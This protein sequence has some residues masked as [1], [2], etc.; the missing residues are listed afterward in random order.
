MLPRH[1]INIFLK[2][3]EHIERIDKT[4]GISE[5][6]YKICKDLLER[7]WKKSQSM[8]LKRT[9]IDWEPYNQKVSSLYWVC[10]T[11]LIAVAEHLLNSLVDKGVDNIKIILPNDEEGCPSYNQLVEF[12]NNPNPLIGNQIELAK[13][14]YEEI[15][16]TLE[17]REKELTEHLRKYSGTMYS[18]ITIYDEDA[19]I[20]FYDKAGIGDENITL[21]F[22]GKQTE[23]YKLVKDLFK[24]MWRDSK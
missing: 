3:K 24:K 13:K 11:S 18:N 15:C 16:K 7:W 21:Q 14:A 10:G 1:R 20:S 9:E 19:F 17:S 23:G 5:D 8:Y 4:M 12:N 2:I 6:I 22:H